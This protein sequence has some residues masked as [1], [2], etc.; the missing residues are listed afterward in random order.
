[1]SKLLLFFGAVLSFVAIV[2]GLSL[3]SFF[4]I[5]AM[6]GA[7]FLPSR[8][9]AVERALKLLKLKPGE[10]LLDLG[11]GTGTVVVAAARRGVRV[12]GYEINPILWFISWLRLRPYGQLA[13]VKLRNYWNKAL[14]RAEGI[15]VF[16][17][18]KYMPKLDAKL[19]AEIKQPTLL[20]SFVFKI[21]GRKIIAQEAGLYLYRYPN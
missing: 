11:S 6:R 15:Y 18:D 7:P 3:V 21:P 20:A 14:P 12:I 10:L 9:L 5:G 2:A 8:K 16:L 4:A 13:S 17:I 19:A 1:M